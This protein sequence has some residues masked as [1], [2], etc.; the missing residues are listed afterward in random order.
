MDTCLGT[1]GNMDTSVDTDV[2]I[3]LL[4][5]MA[6]ML[7]HLYVSTLPLSL[8]SRNIYYIFVVSFLLISLTRGNR[9]LHSSCV[10]SYSLPRVVSIHS[11]SIKKMCR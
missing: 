8:P 10:C 5:L 3:F 6:V 7:A 9:L 4:G 11:D 2:A 1:D